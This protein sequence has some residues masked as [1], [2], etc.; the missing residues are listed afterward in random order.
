MLDADASITGKAPQASDWS[1]LPP[2]DRATAL[3]ACKARLRG[4]GRSLHAVV[5]EFDPEPIICSGP[6]RGMPYVAKDIFA[7]GITA[8]SWGCATPRRP[9]LPRAPA[10][11]RL[12]EAGA[13][14]IATAEMTELAYEPSGHNPVRGSVL[15]PWN[16]DFVTGG[17]SS[18]SAALVASGCCYL[19][20]G[21]DSGGSVRIPAHCC[22]ITA[23]KPS[24]GVLPTQRAMPLAPSLD[25][26]GIMARS[27]ADLALVWPVISQQV[28]F[29]EP[30]CRRVTVLDDALAASD[31]EIARACRTAI[32]ALADIGLTISKAS[33]FPEIADAQSLIVLQAEAARTH[34]ARL[35]DQRID[36]TL[37]KRLRKGLAISD[38]DLVKSLVLR[39][40][41]R[42]DF[43][44]CLPE[45]TDAAL[46]PVMPI[47]TSSVRDVDPLSSAF[48]PRTLYA[49]SR[50]TRF[51]NYLGL[52]A[53]A[54]PV[55]HDSR[56]MPIAVQFVGRFG[57]D[58]VLLDLATRLQS[59]T[60]WH[61][62]MPP[63]AHDLSG[64]LEI[65]R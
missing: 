57:C 55:G 1:S 6:L 17:S 47:T 24:W 60:E 19:A 63:A 58:A 8:P 23:L 50:F 16:A 65:T 21:S 62:A 59:R 4:V 43:L 34:R 15:N 14:L 9:V 37:R 3:A 27:A 49:M 31:P 48:N 38:N 12:D 2:Q 39:E 29:A 41:A 40:A 28:M 35:D 7:T 26:I 5:A 53:I 11:T 61:K 25:T 52:P 36:A 54:L 18:G 20:L 30:R 13:A 10:L 45:E 44:A 32:D 64:E 42:A 46:L 33:G 56:G 51:V 22:G